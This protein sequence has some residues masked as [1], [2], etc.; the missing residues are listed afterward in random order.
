MMCVPYRN[1]YRGRAH[2][3]AIFK[4]IIEEYLASI[5]WMLFQ[6]SF[7]A[8]L[9]IHLDYSRKILVFLSLV[10]YLYI[11]SALAVD[12]SVWAYLHRVYLVRHPRAYVFKLYDVVLDSFEYL[13]EGLPFLYI[14]H[15]LRF[16]F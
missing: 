9:D 12:Y 15:L 4:S 10:S 1:F 5:F 16:L 7:D 3:L 2:K 8:G 11:V 13:S 6:H 14:L